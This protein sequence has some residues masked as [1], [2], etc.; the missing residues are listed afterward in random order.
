MIESRRGCMGVGSDWVCG[1]I[2]Q[3]QCGSPIRRP[4]SRASVQ[5]IGVFTCVCVCLCVCLCL[6]VSVCVASSLVTT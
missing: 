5:F 6:C 1:E 4:P 2:Q 3:A